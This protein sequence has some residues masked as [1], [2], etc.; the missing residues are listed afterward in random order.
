MKLVLA[1]TGASGTIYLQR[2]LDQIDAG[3]ARSPSRP[4]RTR[5][6]GG[7]AGSRS[8]SKI[9]AGVSATRRERSQRSLRQRLRAFRCDGHRSLLDGIVRPN[10]RRHQRQRPA[11]RGRCFSQ[12]TAQ[13]DPRPARDAVES[14]PR[15]Q[16]RHVA[17]SGRD[18]APCDSVVLQPAANG[19][20]RRRHRGLADHRPDRPAESAR[21]PLE[22]DREN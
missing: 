12:G 22:S 10:R 20:R 3:D 19:E 4:E 18:R 14:D 7:G 16:R 9:P 5:P 2:L 11:S 1:A 6:P 8:D 21:L 15:A 13:A 17:R